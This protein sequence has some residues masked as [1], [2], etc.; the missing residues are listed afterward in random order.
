MSP[1]MGNPRRKGGQ[2]FEKLKDQTPDYARAWSF[3]RNP[4]SGILN[5]E[6]RET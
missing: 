2:Q 1:R 6:Q 3:E 4:L 5:Y